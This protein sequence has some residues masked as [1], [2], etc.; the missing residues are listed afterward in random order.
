MNGE[1]SLE[2]WRLYFWMQEGTQSSAA[3]SPWLCAVGPP[4]SSLEVEQ[5]FPYPVARPEPETSL[6]PFLPR[7]DRGPAFIHYKPC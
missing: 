4:S 6:V 5:C 2:T 7:G 1:T 3:S